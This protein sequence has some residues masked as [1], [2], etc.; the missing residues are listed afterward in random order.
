MELMKVIEKRRSVR[1]YQSR[2]VSD[3]ILNRI[4][5]AARLAPSARNRQPWKFIVVRDP[6][7]RRELA[8]AARNQSFIGKAPVVIVGVALD[9]N[10]IMSSGVPAYAVNMGISMEHIALAA[11]NEGLGTCWIGGFSQ[12]EVKKIL[13]VPDA[14]KVACLMPMGY[15]AD[16]QGTRIRKPLEEIIC[17]EQ[18]S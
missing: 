3:E 2:E 18:Y 14:Y 12:E 9:P 16:S 17:Q 15:P 4:L 1:E 13:G 10:H 6:K 5:E 8:E 11:Q 7:R